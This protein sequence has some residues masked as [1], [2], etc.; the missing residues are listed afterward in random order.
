MPKPGETQTQ[1]GTVFGERQPTPGAYT[2]LIDGLTVS[3]YVWVKPLATNP[4][5]I[6]IQSPDAPSAAAAFRLE[7]SSQ[8]VKLFTNRSNATIRVSATVAGC[9]LTYFGSQEE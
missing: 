5:S 6:L 9:T 3:N 8:A 1:F 2:P 4:G 7:A